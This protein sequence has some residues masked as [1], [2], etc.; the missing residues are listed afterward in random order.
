MKKLGK[1]SDRLLSAFLV[2][3]TAHA[4]GIMYCW[5]TSQQ[6]S[7]GGLGCGIQH[8]SNGGAYCTRACFA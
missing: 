4:R 8:C 3:T 6:C 1:I 2:K 5:C 7:C